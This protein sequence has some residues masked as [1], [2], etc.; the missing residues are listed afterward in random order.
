MKEKSALRYS[1]REFSRDGRN[2][3]SSGITSRRIFGTLGSSRKYYQ[4]IHHTTTLSATGAVL[5]NWRTSPMERL[6]DNSD[7]PV[8]RRGILLKTHTRS[9]RK[10]RLHSTFPRRNGCSR[11]NKRASGFR[12]L[13]AHVQQARPWQ[14]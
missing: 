8:A 14:Y 4:G 5:S 11:V 10:T 3:E 13:Y 7:A 9:K 2:E 1:D 6:H 12:S